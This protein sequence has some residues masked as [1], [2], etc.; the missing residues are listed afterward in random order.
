LIFGRIGSIRGW[1]Q[2]PSTAFTALDSGF[3]YGGNSFGDIGS[4]ATVLLTTNGTAPF[5]VVPLPL[6]SGISANRVV[7]RDLN[8]SRVVV[9]SVGTPYGLRWETPTS[10][11]TQLLPGNHGYTVQQVFPEGISNSGLIAGW[12]VLEVRK[13]ATKYAAVVWNGSNTGTPLPAPPGSVS[14]IAS[15]VNDAGTISGHWNDGRK[16]SPIRWTPNGVGGY[17][18]ATQSIDVGGSN[19]PTGIDACSRITGG[20][21]Q[22]AWVWD[23]TSGLTILP[24]VGGT[25]ISGWSHSI[26]QTGELVGSSY[27]GPGHGAV[28][29]ATLWTG[30]P[31]CVL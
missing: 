15:N 10:V 17:N 4:G 22:G 28:Y 16:W 12:V 13:N 14:Q 2:S 9:A 31:P 11:P 30:L 6:P 3:V 23:P 19:G 27:N 26:S 25:G 29:H 1:W 8:D 21:P 5:E 24:S 7:A 20:S 18:I